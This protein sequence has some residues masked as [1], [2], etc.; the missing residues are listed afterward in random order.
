MRNKQRGI[1]LFG[2]FFV[3]MGLVFIALVVMKVI[4]S[5][6]EYVSIKKV[7]NAMVADPQMQDAKPSKIRES[8]VR[9]SGIDNITSV[10]A[11]D[12]DISRDNGKLTLSAKYHVEKPLFDNIG[13]YIDFAPTTAANGAP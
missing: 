6:I 9:R 7:L 10:K 1:S 2:M 11:D 5:Y 12:L 3:A 8:Y 13:I 4:P